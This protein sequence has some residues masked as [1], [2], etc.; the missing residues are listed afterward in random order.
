MKLTR[1]KNEV[2]QIFIITL[3]LLVIVTGFLSLCS[4]MMA[5]SEIIYYI[6]VPSLILL[7]LFTVPVLFICGM[8]KDFVRVFAMGNPDRHFTL[9]EMKRSL[10]ALSLL[11]RQIVYGSLL[12]VVFSIIIILTRLTDLE[13]LGPNVAVICLSVFYAAIT[14]LLLLPLNIYVK[15]RI[16]DYMEEDQD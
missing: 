15:K 16:I 14:E 12:T 13:V 6:D 9:A 2:V 3:L 11:Q 5:F 10:E 4:G 8:Q 1:K 7:F